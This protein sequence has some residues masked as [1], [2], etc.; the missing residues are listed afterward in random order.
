[1]VRAVTIAVALTLA[2]CTTP[3]Q[4]HARA[5]GA[6]IKAATAEAKQCLQIVYDD[7]AFASLRPHRPLLPEDATLEQM[8]DQTKVSGSSPAWAAS[9]CCWI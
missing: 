6:E 4:R 3:A 2:A 7:P 9:R 5:M 8:L 1:M